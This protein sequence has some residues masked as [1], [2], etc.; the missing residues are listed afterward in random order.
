MQNIL[1][2]DICV[3][4]HVYVLYFIEAQYMY[5]LQNI[6]GDDIHVCVYAYLL[7][8]IEAQYMYMYMYVSIAKDSHLPQVL[9]YQF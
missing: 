3:H 8:C 6:L 1:G 5:I 7:Y 4:V 9:V 2:A